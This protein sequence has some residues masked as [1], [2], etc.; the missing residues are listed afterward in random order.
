MFSQYDLHNHST[1][2]DGT[3][4]PGELVV[5][6]AQAGIRVLALTDHDTTEG[7][8][9]ARQM[10]ERVGISLVAGAEIS[11]TWKQQ[12]IHILGL[13]LDV[14]TQPLQQGLAGLRD[15]RQQRAM[16]IAASLAK[17]GISGT[18]A[19][20]KALADG[21]LISRTHFARYLVEQGV[22]GDE[23]EVFKHFLVKGKPG[24]VSSEWA[25]LEQAV[26]WIHRA[27]G[28]AV[29]AHPARYRMTRSKLRR[30]IG[31]FVDLQG[32]A[33]EVVSGTHSRDDYYVMAK[34]AR[35]FRLYASAGS[36]F[37]SPDYP[38]IALGRLPVLPEG[39]RP[40][41]EAWPICEEGGT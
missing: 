27:G 19:G 37:H 38:W 2:S 25:S 22:A 9:E 4:S 15:Y 5:M 3:L 18:Y 6:A 40:I 17:A 39:C 29:I 33:I 30:L 10:A 14:D 13:N 26:D 41:W 23:R 34:H 7:I 8:A 16:R 21:G 11:V 24:F 35:E 32:E 31:E 12:T 20:A 28:Q 1:A 36:D